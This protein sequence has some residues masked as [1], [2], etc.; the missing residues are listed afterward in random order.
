VL[1]VAIQPGRIAAQPLEQR[2]QRRAA[3][4]ARRDRAHLALDQRER[5]EAALVHLLGPDLERGRVVE[6]PAVAGE[7]ARVRGD[8]DR[9]ARARRVL[10]RE[11]VAVAPQ[12]RAHR[13]ALLREEA[14][15]E[16]GIAV[17][18]RRARK[19]GVLGRRRNERVELP[20]DEIDD[21]ARRAVALREPRAQRLDL[22]AHV[23]RQPCEARERLLAQLGRPDRLRLRRIGELHVPAVR[24]LAD[25]PALEV[26]GAQRP[27]AIERVPREVV[28]EA[29]VRRHLPAV[30]QLIQLAPP[31]VVPLLA[32]GDA[33]ER[34]VRQPV[35]ANARW[36]QARGA[37]GELLV[38]LRHDRV[39]DREHA[40]VGGRGLGSAPARERERDEQARERDAAHAEPMPRGSCERPS[41]SSV[42]DAFDA[43][44]VWSEGRSG[45]FPSSVPERTDTSW[46]VASAWL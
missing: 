4:A 8:A 38:A 42:Q 22:V 46:R 15:A 45:G 19:G 13:V 12:R 31:G 9:V 23:A 37:P 7:P 28:G 40:R 35:V 18:Q 41:W 26:A 39:R 25:A 10:V 30:E 24:H 27:A 3:E 33:R 16:G 43:T 6:R 17:A 44:Q 29:R 14:L 11:E 32:R 20:H 1:A 36:T 2:G 34:V 5:R 21:P